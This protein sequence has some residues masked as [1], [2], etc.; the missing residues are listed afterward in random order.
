[1]LSVLLVI[2]TTSQVW[3]LN[4]FLIPYRRSAKQDWQVYLVQPDIFAN[5]YGF[6]GDLYFR[7]YEISWL[8]KQVNYTTK[9]YY[10]LEN[11]TVGTY[12]L[13]R[14]SD[15]VIVPPSMTVSVF[16]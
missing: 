9:Q 13:S 10:E 5:P 12:Y 14:D 11:M 1:M 2:L 7:I 8:V 16:A 4:K 15:G 3:I 6:G